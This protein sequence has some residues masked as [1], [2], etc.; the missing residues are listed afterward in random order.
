VAQT[1]E[2]HWWIAEERALLNAQAQWEVARGLAMSGEAVASAAALRLEWLVAADQ[3]FAEFDAIAL[4]S[5]QVWP[6]PADWTW[7]KEIAGR[8]MD[9]YHRW[10]ECVIPASLGGFPALNVP[11]GV[12]ANGLPHGIQLIGR[13]GDDAKTLALGRAYEALIGPRDIIDPRAI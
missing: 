10:M 6:F 4:P 5:T 8:A 13:A 11:G 2:P 7:P 12:A 9:T 3:L 1:R